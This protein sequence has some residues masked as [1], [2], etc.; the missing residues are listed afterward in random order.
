[1][2]ELSAEAELDDRS[3]WLGWQRLLARLGPTDGRDGSADDFLDAL[4]DVVGADRAML[5]VTWP[6]GTSVPINGRAAGRA[7]SARER[8]QLTRTLVREAEQTG[9]CVSFSALDALS[10]TQSAQAFGILAAFAAPLE[11]RALQA[12]GD[13]AISRGVL[14]VDFRERTHLASPR[15]AEFVSAAAALLSALLG[16]GQ[17]LQK[18]REELR[19]E[20][21]RSVGASRAVPLEQLLRGPSLE[22][23]RRDVRACLRSDQPVLITG[24]SGTGKTE[25]SRALAEA[26]GRLP[27]VR[28]TLGGSDDLNTIS[29]ELFGH[30]K[31]AFS[32]ALG[33]RVGL[34][35]FAHRGTLIFDEILNLPRHAQQLLLDFTQFGTY[36][37]LGWER[38]EPKESRVRLVCATNG[39]LDAAV[40]DGR[41]RADLYYRIA[42]FRLHLPPLRERRAELPA[43][44]LDFLSRIEPGRRWAIDDSLRALLTADTWTWPGNFR[45]LEVVLRRARDRALE[46]DPEADCL[47]AAHVDAVD[48]GGRASP[49]VAPAPPAPSTEGAPAWADLQRRREELELL[50]QD[51]IRAALERNGGVVSRAARELGLPRTSLLSRMASFGLDKTSA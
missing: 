23:L 46:A 5:L 9:R 3:L 7:L 26:S 35:E 47:G 19:V 14:Y 8:E 48:L 42:G 12:G 41:L 37:P 22:T 36:R 32:G 15:L 39:D 21:V 25:M 30:E 34:V 33:K 31:G 29:S 2:R 27:V 50:E 28:A 18:A 6:D 44:A 10:S 49:P 16:Q 4:A 24:E 11:A 51:T 17:R 1:M 40:A 20:R 38:P 13:D 45:Q 43:L